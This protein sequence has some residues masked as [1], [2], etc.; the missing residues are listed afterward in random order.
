MEKKRLV[1]MEIL[2]M[3]S[4]FMIIVIHIVNH[5]SMIDLVHADTASY[6]IVWFLFGIGFTS[7]NLYILISGYFLA[8]SKF[9]SW[10]ILRMELQVLFYALGITLIFWIAGL[11]PER[12]LKV[13]VMSATPIASDFYWFATMYVGMYLMSPLLNIFARALTKRQYQC[14]LVLLFVLFSVW[15]NVFYW[16]SG[17][18][19]AGGVAVMWFLV[20]YLAGAYL[21]LHYTPDEKPGKWLRAGIIFSLLIPLSRV[22]ILLLIKTPLGNFPMLEDLLWGYS[23]FYQ[24]NSIIVCIAAGALF[25]AF[26]NMP[27]LGSGKAAPLIRK[28]ASGVF[29]IY[30]IHDHLYFRDIV[31]DKL[32][33]YNWLYHW[34]LVP[35]ILLTAVIIFLLG[36]GIDLIRSYIFDV[37]EKK[38]RLKNLCI[39]FD[40][41]LRTKWNG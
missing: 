4:M 20:V 15:T 27:K 17:M 19:I 25:I 16:T 40:N 9:S 21:R 37:I 33:C 18:N 31:I 23:L 13:L 24:Y 34:Y 7:I 28:M 22:I 39:R 41:W 26:L 32:A 35:C 2:R 11:A 1:N 6:Y 14:T 5:G 29:G 38:I 10:K 36:I 3:I 12:E 30:L 8:E